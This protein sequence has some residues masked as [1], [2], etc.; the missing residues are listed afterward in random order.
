MSETKVKIGTHSGAFHSDETLACS[1]LKILP[2]F[3]DA[4][5]V[6]SRD[7]AVL[8]DCTVVVDVGAEFD[9]AR[10]RFDHHQ[11]SFSHSFNSLD[12]PPCLA[13]RLCGYTTISG[14]WSAL[15]V[16]IKTNLLKKSSLIL[17][18]DC[19]LNGVAELCGLVECDTT[20]PTTVAFQ[21]I[22][23]RQK[24]KLFLA[25]NP[26]FGTFRNRLRVFKPNHVYN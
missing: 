7:L 20:V 12:R 9:P 17:T 10:L 14:G 4:E 13:S 8:A 11:A 25:V 2:R 16:A 15:R 22:K 19:Q 6:R 5:I 3:K 26:V 23:Y 1:L 18:S 21:Q 24:M